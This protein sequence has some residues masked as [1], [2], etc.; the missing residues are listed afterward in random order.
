MRCNS[1]TL[2]RKIQR[3]GFTSA[4]L[5]EEFEYLGHAISTHSSHPRIWRPQAVGDLRTTDL[6]TVLRCSNHLIPLIELLPGDP[7]VSGCT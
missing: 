3:P 7:T 1:S 2:L 6:T 5:F 4:Q